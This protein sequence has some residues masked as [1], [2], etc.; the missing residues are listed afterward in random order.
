M[1]SINR[2]LVHQRISLVYDSA[3][4]AQATSKGIKDYVKALRQSVGLKNESAG[5]AS[6]FVR[7]F[8]MG[9]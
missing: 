1:D 5:N 2:Q 8:G 6:D 7:D 3:T 4:G 9:I